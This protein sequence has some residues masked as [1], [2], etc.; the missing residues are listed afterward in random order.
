M[1][2]DVLDGDAAVAAVAAGQLGL[3]RRHQLAAAGLGRRAVERRLRERRLHRLYQGVYLVGH[4]VPPPLARELGAIF[5]C[6]ERAVLSHTTAARLWGLLDPEET[7]I[8]VTVIGGRR[9]RDGIVVHRTTRLPRTDVGRRHGLPV[10]SAARTVL[11]CADIAPDTELARIFDEA[12]IQRR[13]SRPQLRA[14][15]DRVPGR[16]GA[17]RVVALLDRNKPPAFTRSTGERRLLALIRAGGLPEPRV[18]TRV[19][20]HELDLYWPEEGLNVELDAWEVHRDR[21]ARDHVRDTALQAAGI[22]VV[23][24]T[25]RQLADAA[26]ATLVRITRA[27]SPGCAPRSAADR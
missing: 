18:N 9:H 19:L 15:V 12:L 17:A 16:R 3:V 21:L 6:G 25:G 8:H 26:E 2:S 27:L 24:V 10:T 1:V 5:A 22:R 20:G 11:D 7:G 14:A 4:P 23:R 13:T